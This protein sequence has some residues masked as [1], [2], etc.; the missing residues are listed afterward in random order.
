MTGDG[1]TNFH[2]HYHRSNNENTFKDEKRFVMLSGSYVH[3]PKWKKVMAGSHSDGT[4]L[5]R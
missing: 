2:N 1:H 3:A 5:Y 4:E